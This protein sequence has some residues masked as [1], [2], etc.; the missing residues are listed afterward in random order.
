MA[1]AKSMDSLH[2]CIPLPRSQN[3]FFKPQN[4]GP[5]FGIHIQF[6]EATKHHQCLQLKLQTLPEN[7]FFGTSVQALHENHS[8]MTITTNT[9]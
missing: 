7:A 1:Y 4:V 5:K 3:H 9:T 6:T 8:F 2:Q